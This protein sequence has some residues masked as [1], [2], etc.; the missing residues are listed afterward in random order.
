L[1]MAQALGRSREWLVAHPEGALSEEQA[2]DFRDFC[3][4]RRMGEPIAYIV[5][6]AGFYGREFIVNESVL[7]PRPETEH[8]IDEAIAFIRGPMHVLDVGTGCGAIACTI[9]AET[10]ATVDATDSSVAAIDV[11]RENARRLGASERVRFHDGDLTEPVR[12]HR[13]DVIVANLPYV[14]RENLPKPPDS[15]S[16]EPRAALDGGPDGLAHYRRLL[17]ELP[18]LVNEDAML[19]FECARPTFGALRELVRLSFPNFLI[20]G[21][22]DYAGLPRYIKA[23]AKRPGELCA[24]S[25]ASESGRSQEGERPE[26]RARASARSARQASA[27]AAYSDARAQSQRPGN[28]ATPGEQ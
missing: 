8:L 6:S 26:N 24:A 2:S 13:Y 5:G 12:H 19:L 16:F 21:G 14:P 11:A 15:A 9:A 23:H 22:N 10:A 1:L 28:Q 7:V 25:A 20:E 18:P 4:R 17:P 27:E 3:E